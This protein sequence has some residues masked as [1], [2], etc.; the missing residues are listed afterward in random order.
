MRA[1]KI[2]A[3]AAIVSAV[4]LVGG[5][6][7]VTASATT[8]VAS[9]VQSSTSF[10][11]GADPHQA[12]LSP[13][14]KDLWIIL[15]DPQLANEIDL[16]THKVIKSISIVQYPRLSALSPNGKQLWITGEGDDVVG[17]YSVAT[18]VETHTIP[19]GEFPVG[20][21]FNP[22]GNQVWVTN[23]YGNS[24]SVIDTSSYTVIETIPVPN[25]WTISFNRSGSKAYA[26]TRA[27][28]GDPDTVSIIDTSTY[29]TTDSISGVGPDLVYSTASPNGSRL[30]FVS[31]DEPGTLGVYSPGQNKVLALITLGNDPWFATPSP[32]GSRIYVANRD[33]DTVSVV[34]ASSLKVIATIPTG[35]GSGPQYVAFSKA[36]KTV[37]IVNQASE[38]VTIVSGQEQKSANVVFGGPNPVLN[39]GNRG[40]L[41]SLKA[42]IPSGAKYV[43]VHIVGYTNAEPSKSLD[44]SRAKAAE[45]YLK[46]LG[47]S[48]TYS[49][50][51]GGV[52]A[53]EAVVTVTYVP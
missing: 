12:I 8:T 17:V 37:Y 11:S 40:I 9:A 36:G 20:L 51:S 47:L 4:S 23:N 2:I 50:A 53:R 49:V 10:P 34:D 14:G 52:K 24:V 19:V 29:T 13:N 3:V 35:A 1:P 16:R 30:Y 38:K 7:A 33:G 46:S 27:D 48:A 15:Y 25:P 21:A 28:Y 44:I 6:A 42:S 41:K 39:A 43:T 32:D 22:T 31:Q 18:G 5:L 45:S 26:S